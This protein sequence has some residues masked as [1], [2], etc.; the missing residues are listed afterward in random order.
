MKGPMLICFFFEN[1]K[2]EE[3]PFLFVTTT[4]TNIPRKLPVYLAMFMMSR[5]DLKHVNRQS[6]A[7]K[8]VSVLKYVA[9]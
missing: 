6:L 4:A 1:V 7:V 5:K 2:N 8:R 9:R 3:N